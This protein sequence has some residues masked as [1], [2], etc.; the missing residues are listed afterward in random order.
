MISIELVKKFVKVFAPGYY[1][2]KMPKKGLARRRNGHVTA[3]PESVGFAST[4]TGVPVLSKPKVA[5]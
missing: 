1:L 3:T 4:S 2:A 5:S